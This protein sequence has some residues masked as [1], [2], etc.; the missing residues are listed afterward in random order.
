MVKLWR[1]ILSYH[2]KHGLIF[3]YVHVLLVVCIFLHW[4]I[5]ILKYWNDFYF[6]FFIIKNPVFFDGDVVNI[7]A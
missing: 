4:A 3:H 2:G 5:L 1:A 7:K 6:N